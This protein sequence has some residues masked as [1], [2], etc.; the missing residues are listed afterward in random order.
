MG[1]VMSQGMQSDLAA[2]YV[3]TESTGSMT[4]QDDL[5]TTRNKLIVG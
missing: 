2:Y 4:V 5:L 3:H 1:Y